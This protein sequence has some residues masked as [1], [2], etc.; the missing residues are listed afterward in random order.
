MG[1]VAFEN[2]QTKLDE[3]K[4]DFDNWKKLSLNADFPK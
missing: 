2:T 3:L 1:D 4:M